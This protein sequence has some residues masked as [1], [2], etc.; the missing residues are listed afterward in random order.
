MSEST[1][2]FIIIDNIKYQLLK[3]ISI[4]NK[5]NKNVIKYKAQSIDTEKPIKYVMI[6]RIYEHEKY[7]WT[8]TATFDSK[9]SMDKA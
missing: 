9:E 1:K 5:D 7:S 6:T 3:S 8:V 2:K 4:M